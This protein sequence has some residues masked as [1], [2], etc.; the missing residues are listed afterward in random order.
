ML[1]LTSTAVSDEERA[2]VQAQLIAGGAKSPGLPGVPPSPG[3]PYVP[4][5]ENSARQETDEQIKE[6]V[7][8]SKRISL[9]KLRVQKELDDELPPGFVVQPP[10]P[11]GRTSPKPFEETTGKDKAFSPPAEDSASALPVVAPPL[12]ETE[13]TPFVPPQGDDDDDRPPS[14]KP[15]KD[16]EDDKPFS[17]PS[18]DAGA[19]KP[20]SP[21]ADDAAATDTVVPRKASAER[22]PGPPSIAGPRGP[23]VGGPRGARLATPSGPPAAGASDAKVSRALALLLASSTADLATRLD[24]PER[25]ASPGP[26]K[27]C[28]SDSIANLVRWRKADLLASVR[29]LSQK[30]GG[31]VSDRSRRPSLTT[32]PDFPFPPPPPYDTRTPSGS[33]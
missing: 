16:D 29:P 18:E 20:F 10:T 32:P 2:N 1:S 22:K 23:R 8:T 25:V 28:E 13:D 31:R 27:S 19:E 30:P 7:E 15:P 9:S 5:N 14:F 4:R 33:E 26:P 3:R 11:I 17:P 12:A 21:P 24:V 6:R